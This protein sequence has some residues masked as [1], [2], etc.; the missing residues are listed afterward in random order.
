MKLDGY[1]VEELQPGVKLYRRKNA[2]HTTFEEGCPW[3]HFHYVKSDADGE[4]DGETDVELCCHGCGVALWVTMPFPAPEAV[5]VQAQALRAEF[6]LNH[7]EHNTI[8]I[9]GDA[10][11]QLFKLTHLLRDH[12]LTFLCPDFRKQLFSVTLR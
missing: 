9:E 3:I 11:F 5:S 10:P 6:K 4:R 7:E 8:F 2:P 12:P 1:E